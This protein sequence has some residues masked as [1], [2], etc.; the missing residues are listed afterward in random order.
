M[1]RE[2]EIPLPFGEEG[3]GEYDTILPT[4]LYRLVLIRPYPDERMAK[5]ILEG[6]LNEDELYVSTLARYRKLS[7]KLKQPR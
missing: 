4:E 3:L 5:D 6:R 2:K 1:I 7:D